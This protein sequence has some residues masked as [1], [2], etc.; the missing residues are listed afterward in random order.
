MWGNKVI[1]KVNVV[2]EG[3]HLL[4]KCPNHKVSPFH[5]R[6]VCGGETSLDDTAVYCGDC[7]S[8][9]QDRQLLPRQEDYKKN[10]MRDG[11]KRSKVSKFLKHLGGLMC[12][13]APDNPGHALPFMAFGTSMH[14]TGLISN[15]NLGY[16][17]ER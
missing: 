7:V 2:F 13:K 9:F 6:H 17:Q 10:A 16:A 14:Y 12:H 8:V 1:S 11:T 15:M 3:L 4:L 5:Q